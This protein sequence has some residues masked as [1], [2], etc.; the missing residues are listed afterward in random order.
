MDLLNSHFLDKTKLVATLGNTTIFFVNFKI[1]IGPS[2]QAKET[3]KLK[4]WNI[5]EDCTSFSFNDIRKQKIRNSIVQLTM[6]EQQMQIVTI[7]IYLNT[8]AYLSKGIA[9]IS[10]KYHSISK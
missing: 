9:T 3:K 1:F 5:L 6:V 7:C 10:A 8:A 4:F 2:L